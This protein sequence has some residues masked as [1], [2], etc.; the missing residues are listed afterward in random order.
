MKILV[1]S[2]PPLAPE[3]GAAQMA[4]NL[5]A[6]L[7]ERGHEATPWSPEPLPP[8]VRWWDRWIWQ[9]RRLEEF[10][11]GRSFDVIDL[12]SISISPRIAAQAL[13]VARSVQPELLYLRSTQRERLRLF[14][15][16]PLR[17]TAEAATW[18]WVARAVR[19][20]WHRAHLILCLGSL[21]LAWMRERFPRLGH[22]LAMYV[23]ALSAADQEALAPLRADRRPQPGP[24]T[25]FLWLG[26]WVAHKGIRRLVRFLAERAATHPDDTFTL[27]GCG[28]E[29]LADCPAGLV[30][31]GRV[32]A[33]PSFS[34]SELPALL[35][36]HDAGLF[37]SEVEGWG[38]SLNEMLE[39]GLP[40]YA[41]RAGGVADLGPC[42]PRSLRP[43]PPPDEIDPVVDRDL[44][45]TGYYERFTWPRIAAQYEE[46]VLHRLAG[47]AGKSP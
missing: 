15:K 36:R 34:R 29:A 6:A 9:R 39:A 25:R 24:G 12:P 3:H 13:I 20:G 11:Q 32:Q 35:A 5:A 21:E 38:L 16:A 26:R 46:T 19:S 45:A 40:V 10:L 42:V 31:G 8:Q 43:F 7:Q 37:T 1:V 41:T 27:A 44:G 30:H 33:V 18:P 2:H 14:P 4:L 17:I 47:L 23:N 28:S 22:R